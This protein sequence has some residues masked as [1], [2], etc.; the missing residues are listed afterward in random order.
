MEVICLTE[1]AQFNRMRHALTDIY[2]S[3]YATIPEYA[4]TTTQ[5][6]WH[7]LKWLF[8][9]S[10]GGFFLLLHSELPRGFI[11]TDPDW[12]DLDDKRIGEIHE[13]VVTREFQGRGAGSLLLHCGIRFLYSRKH[14]RIGLWVGARNYRAIHFYLRHGFRY[15][16]VRGV[17]QRMYL[18]TDKVELQ[19]ASGLPL[20]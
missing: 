13:L 14:R 9:R 6:I 3:G 12:R 11:C 16:P 1:A 20:Q 7:Y 2:L 4:Y 17:W 10:R 19:T 15:G 5:D 8:H 18:D